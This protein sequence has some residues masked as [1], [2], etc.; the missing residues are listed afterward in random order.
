MTVKSTENGALDDQA[1]DRANGDR[2][3]TADGEL[4]SCS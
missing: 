2:E 1:Q 4:P 3:R